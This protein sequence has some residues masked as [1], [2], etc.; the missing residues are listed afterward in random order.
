ME[1][2][3]SVV[4]DGGANVKEIFVTTASAEAFARNENAGGTMPQAGAAGKPVPSMQSK[5]RA[6]FSAA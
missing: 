4:N 2:A 6:V 1:E 3:G 5:G